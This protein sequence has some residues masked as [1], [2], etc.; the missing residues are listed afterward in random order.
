M[1]NEFLDYIEDI[2]EAM[3]KA[4]IAI[5]GVDYDRFAADFMINFVVVRA[6]EIVGEAAKRLPMSLR[7]QY[8]HIPWREMAGMRDRII[9]GYDTVDLEVVWEVV[10]EDIPQVKPQLRQ[11]LA[12]YGEA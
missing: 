3:D 5:A 7:N 6:L 11:I 12:D 1:S 10:T 4:E 2:I 8:P 9:H